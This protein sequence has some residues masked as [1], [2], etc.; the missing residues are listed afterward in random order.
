MR[1]VE[2]ATRGR[3]DIRSILDLGCGTGRFSRALS[4]HFEARVLAIDP[5]T[6]MLAAARSKQ[7]TPHVRHVLARGEEIPLN[8]G[9]VDLIFMSMVLHHFSNPA[10]VA[11]ECRRVLRPNGVAF[12]RAGVTDRIDS[13][14]YVPFFP[15]SIP[16]LYRIL[17]S[18]A[19][20]REVFENAGF[21]TATHDIL[22][23]EIAASHG[24]YC[25]KLEAG[26]DSVLAR[27][28]EDEFRTGIAKLRAFCADV[29][30][31]PVVEPI[32]YFAFGGRLGMWRW[33]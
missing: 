24:E 8:D 16:L 10:Q 13:Y 31:K 19:Y 22:V 9:S 23:Q 33:W 7:D 30:P 12:M 14:P 21:R 18:C 28:S 4:D 29:D 1:A 2:A 3:R 17:P 32:D 5:S 6:T 15:T 25:D 20:I 11:S 26:G 27:L